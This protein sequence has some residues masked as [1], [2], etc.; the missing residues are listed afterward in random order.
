MNTFT[1]LNYEQAPLIGLIMRIVEILTS[2]DNK[3][4]QIRNLYLIWRL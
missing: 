4:Q 3:I 2:S 1:T